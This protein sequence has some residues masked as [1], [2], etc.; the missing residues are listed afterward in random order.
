ML[1]EFISWHTADVCK[2]AEDDA[3]QLCHL[4]V[5]YH[6][7]YYRGVPQYARLLTLPKHLVEVGVEDTDA[8]SLHHL[9]REGWRLSLAHRRQLGTVANEHHP[10]I[11]PV[12]HILDKVVQQLSVGKGCVAIA[13]SIGHH[14]GLVDDEQRVVLGIVA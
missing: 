7:A 11:T 2:A 14:R 5:S 3:G 10:T 9:L 8:V 13:R 1:Y 6:L 4:V 12:I